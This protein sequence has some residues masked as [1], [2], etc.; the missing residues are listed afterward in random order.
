MIDFSRDEN[1]NVNDPGTDV[2]P[3]L[4]TVSDGRD[5]KGKFTKG[6]RASRGNATA[7]KAARFR[8]NL[9]QSVSVA[10]FRQIVQ[11]LISEAKGGESW[12]VKLAFEYLLGPPRDEELEGRINGLEAMLNETQ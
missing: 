1:N 6:N 8:A 11:Q 10:D 3:P 2:T 12:A 7:R 9:Y 5:A 4:P